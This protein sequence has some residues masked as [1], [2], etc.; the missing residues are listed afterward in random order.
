MSYI[1]HSCI[2]LS[3][4]GYHF[5]NRSL[6][7]FTTLH[8]VVI[9][10][11]VVRASDLWSTGCEFV[12]CRVSTWTGDRL[13]AGETSRYVTSH[14]DQLSLPSQQG[15]VEA[16]IEACSHRS[17]NRCLGKK[18]KKCV[19]TRL[20]DAQKNTV[21]YKSKGGINQVLTDKQKQY[22]GYIMRW[23]NVIK[24]CLLYCWF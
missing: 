4:G 16:H 8:N 22:T 12:H 20:E 2:V 18:L 13:W 14:L 1:R 24:Y 23:Q 11:V 9:G 21:T 17:A 5:S 7:R 6:F 10:S 19:Q 3:H 15:T